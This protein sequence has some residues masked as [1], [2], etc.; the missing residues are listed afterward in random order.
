M[1]M[2]TCDWRKRKS[3]MKEESEHK[4]TVKRLRH[5]PQFPV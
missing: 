1:S 3:Q 4:E 5:R 2:T